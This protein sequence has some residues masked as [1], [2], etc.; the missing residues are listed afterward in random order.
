MD[1]LQGCDSNGKPELVDFDFKIFD[2]FVFQDPVEVPAYI[3]YEPGVDPFSGT[4]IDRPFNPTDSLHCANSATPSRPWDSAGSWDSSEVTVCPSPG[5]NDDFP[6]PKAKLHHSDTYHFLPLAAP[7]PPRE[8]PTR[9]N[10]PRSKSRNRQTSGDGGEDLQLESEGGWDGKKPGLRHNSLPEPKLNC[11]FYLKDPAK[12]HKCSRLWVWKNLRE[13]LFRKHRQPAKKTRDRLGGETTCSGAAIDEPFGITKEQEYAIRRVR[14][15]KRMSLED[16][17]FEIWRII[18][19]DSSCPLPHFLIQRPPEDDKRSLTEADFR[20]LSSEEFRLWVQSFPGMSSVDEDQ[21]AEIC[22]ELIQTFNSRR[23]GQD[24]PVPLA[25]VSQQEDSTDK[26]AT[27]ETPAANQGEPVEFLQDLEYLGDVFGDSPLTS[28]VASSPDA[29]TEPPLFDSIRRILSADP[30]YAAEDVI[31]AIKKRSDGNILA[32]T[33]EP[34]SESPIIDSLKSEAQSGQEC[35]SRG[36][37]KRSIGASGPSETPANKK[38][39]TCTPC[40]ADGVNEE[41]GGSNDDAG[42]DGGGTSEDGDEVGEDGEKRG[43]DGDGGG[44]EDRGSGGGG[45]GGGT[46]PPHTPDESSGG[47]I[48]PYCLKFVEIT[49]VKGFKACG[50]PGFRSRD[51]LR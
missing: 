22:K 31:S 19:P 14:R 51:Q 48:C 34:G 13:H 7:K 12:H 18:F 44:D 40:D 30:S 16:V 36:T 15:G 21:R 11:P 43:S 38:Q 10:A 50:R 25:Q 3:Q 8:S 9:R 29:E 6:G 5:H 37:N 23:L 42:V 20:L 47:W 32:L 26:D 41:R 39:K 1:S 46:T 35:T 33:T 49:S 45:G 24:I 28:S 17:W 2:E 4:R 27:P